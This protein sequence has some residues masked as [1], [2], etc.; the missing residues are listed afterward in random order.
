MSKRLAALKQLPE[1]YTK[2]VKALDT[3]AATDQMPENLLG[4]KIESLLGTTRPLEV[5]TL[6][7]QRVLAE[8]YLGLH[9][10]WKNF[11]E[12]YKELSKGVLNVKCA[13]AARLAADLAGVNADLALQIIRDIRDTEAALGQARRQLDTVEPSLESAKDIRSSLE[14]AATS[15]SG[16]QA[17]IDILHHIA[18]QQKLSAGENKQPPLPLRQVPLPEAVHLATLEVSHYR[19]MLGSLNFALAIVSL[20][21][22]LVFGLNEVYWGKVFGW[23]QAALTAF[24]WGLGTK[25]GVDNIFTA[26][27]RLFNTPIRPAATT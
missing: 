7:A 8:T 6:P 23:P 24:A 21:L 18:V 13:Y 20:L 25:I 22:A 2:W 19:L 16:A 14:S 12:K 26:L 17:M 5:T 10:V 15:L 9:P 1:E 3:L 11:E 4:Q 27:S